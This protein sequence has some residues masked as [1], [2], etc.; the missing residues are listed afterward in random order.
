MLALLMASLIVWFRLLRQIRS[1]GDILPLRPRE[2]VAWPPLAGVLAFLAALLVPALLLAYV[3]KVPPGASLGRVQ[4]MV[5]GAVL[6]VG[7]SVGML[8]LA[9]PLRAEDFGL[10][11]IHWRQDA[12]VARDAFLVSL[13]PV[14]GVNVLIDRLGWRAPDGKHEFFKILEAHPGVVTVLWIGL[15]VVVLAPLVEEL[16]FRVILQGSLEKA[17]NPWVAIVITALL[18]A[19]AHQGEGR[20][21]AIPLFPL[22]LAFGYVYHRLRSF[23]AVVLIH[24]IFNAANLGMALLTR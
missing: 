6:Q 13:I 14:Y 9:G 11:G 24:A 16:L 7:L 21:D 17:L 5:A 22:A 4:L 18:F 10:K 23:V 3:V 12:A 2:P 20:P 1:G 15:A 19:A 8:A